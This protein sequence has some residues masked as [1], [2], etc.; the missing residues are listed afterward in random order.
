MA[1]TSQ[2]TGDEWLLRALGLHVERDE[3]TEDDISKL[4]Y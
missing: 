3:V 1:K 2:C 4:T